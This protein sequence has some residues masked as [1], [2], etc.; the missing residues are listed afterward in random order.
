VETLGEIK[1]STLQEL[2]LPYRTKN[3][4]DTIMQELLFISTIDKP[5]LE[6]KH[7]HLKI[8][9]QVPDLPLGIEKCPWQV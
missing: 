8:M 9:L 7:G 3:L 4:R 5:S 1:I 6:S 2:N